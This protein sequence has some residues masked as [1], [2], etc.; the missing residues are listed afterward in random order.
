MACLPSYSARDE[1]TCT[2]KNSVKQ[3]VFV[4]LRP[5]G[6]L[7]STLLQYFFHDLQ[8]LALSVK[9]LGTLFYCLTNLPFYPSLT[10]SRLHLENFYCVKY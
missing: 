2:C 7:C 8:T 5:P 4:K 9:V 10:E 1:A 3:V 6:H